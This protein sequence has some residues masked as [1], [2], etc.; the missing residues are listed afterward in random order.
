MNSEFAMASAAHPGNMPV[1]GNVVG[2]VG[3]H[4]LGALTGQ[5]SVICRGFQ[6]IL[7]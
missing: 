6:R 4:H 3:E 2:R 7:A 5:Q 1:D